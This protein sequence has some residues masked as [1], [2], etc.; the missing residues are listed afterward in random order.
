MKELIPI[1]SKENLFLSNKESRLKIQNSDR[2]F[3]CRHINF[4]PQVVGTA[5]ASA[6]IIIPRFQ[7]HLQEK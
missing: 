4:L 7:N 6:D 3:Y 1:F 2:A 5:L